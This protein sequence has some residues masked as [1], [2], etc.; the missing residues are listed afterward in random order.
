MAIAVKSSVAIIL[1]VAEATI[2][3]LFLTM[4]DNFV[5]TLL[6]RDFASEKSDDYY[7]DLRQ[8]NDYMVQYDGPR[9]FVLPKFPVNSVTSVIESPDSTAPTTLVANT[10]YFVNLAQGTV[11]LQD[12]YSPPV[13][14]RKLKITYKYDYSTAPSDVIDFANYYAALLKESNPLPKNSDG[15][16]LAEVEIG[17]YREKYVTSDAVLNTKYGKFLTELEGLLVQKYKVWE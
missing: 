14:Q 7:L 5:K 12:D 9:E 6:N 15:A 2:D 13:G 3:T 8:K 4:A 16:L 17:R 10:D 11:T 1:G